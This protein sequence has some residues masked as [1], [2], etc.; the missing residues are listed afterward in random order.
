VVDCLRCAVPLSPTGQADP[1]RF[2]QCPRCGRAFTERADG[3]LV[4][5]WLGPLSVALYGVIFDPRPQ[6]PERVRAVADTLGHLDASRIAAEIRLELAHPTQP[7][8]EI[9]GPMRAG[10]DD[11]REFLRL[12]A[13]ELERR[14]TS[15]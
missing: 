11:L 8:G 12:L 10:E 4:E 5:R 9:V 7:V 14:A 6:E 15:R 3:T 2:H 13:D 1:L